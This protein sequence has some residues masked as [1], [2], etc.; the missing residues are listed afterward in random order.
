MVVKFS[1]LDEKDLE[2]SPDLQY[3]YAVYSYITV[4]A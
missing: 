1:V 4:E 2:V 3:L